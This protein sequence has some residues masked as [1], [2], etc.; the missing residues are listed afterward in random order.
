MSTN[1]SSDLEALKSWTLLDY[2]YQQ[3]RSCN[4]LV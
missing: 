1:S 2:K 4:W 3:A